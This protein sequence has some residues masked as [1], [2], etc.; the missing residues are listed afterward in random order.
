M[1]K[2][3]TLKFGLLVRLLCLLMIFISKITFAQDTIHVKKVFVNNRPVKVKSGFI[4]HRPDDTWIVNGKQERLGEYV[5]TDRI[6]F[7]PQE[8]QMD[9]I[10]KK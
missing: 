2:P 3:P 9:S 7:R 5:P 8:T 1:K 6:A 10:V 4:I